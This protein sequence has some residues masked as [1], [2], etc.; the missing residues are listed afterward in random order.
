MNKRP[1]EPPKQTPETTRPSPLRELWLA[2]C[3][4][5]TVLCMLLLLISAIVSDS[6]TVT[7]VDTVRFVLLLPFAVCLALATNLRRT[8]KLKAGAKCVLHPLLTMGG[9]YLF[10]Y[11]PFQ[12]RSK[13]SGQQILLMLILAILVYGLIMGVVC[14][15]SRAQRRKQLEDTPYVSQYNRK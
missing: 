5:Y 11:L 1:A 13:P 15:V 12:L 8:D 14:L 4:R 10:G 7:Y 3:A 6:L 9:F 2:S